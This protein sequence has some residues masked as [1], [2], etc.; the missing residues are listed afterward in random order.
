MSKHH[1]G[2]GLLEDGSAA[3]WQRGGEGVRS[4][5]DSLKGGEIY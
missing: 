1:E 5:L 3:P 2:G 4:V